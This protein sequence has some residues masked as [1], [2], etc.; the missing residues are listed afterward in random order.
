MAII[1][2]GKQFT[3]ADIKLTAGNLAAM[4]VD[5]AQSGQDFG[6]QLSTMADADLIALGLTQAECDTIK[7]F[8]N[9]ELPAIITSIKNSY[10]LRS[11]LGLGV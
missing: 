9:G 5:H 7:G 6:G 2:A 4:I 10:H 3:A 1:Q 11:L 8:Y